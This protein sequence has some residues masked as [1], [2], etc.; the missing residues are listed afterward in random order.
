MKS[1]KDFVA[2]I[3]TSPDD[4]DLRLVYADWLEERGDPRGELVRA[5]EEMRMLAPYSDEYWSLKPIRDRLRSSCKKKWLETMRYGT[6]YE[7]TLGDIPE[8]WKER[9]RLLRAWVDRWHRVSLG[10]IG[11]QRDRIAEIQK[12]IGY[13]LPPSIQEWIAFIRD[14]I[15]AKG[16]GNVFRDALSFGDVPDHAAFSLMV[17][18]EDDYHWAVRKKHLREKDPPVDGYLLDYD[19]DDCRFIHDRV[20]ASR[21]TAWAFSH[22]LTYLGISSTGGCG[23]PVAG[24]DV[25]TLREKLRASFPVF[26]RLEDTE[27]FEAPNLIAVMST[28]RW[29]HR[30]DKHLSVHAWKPVP[31]PACLR[32]YSSAGWS[33]GFLAK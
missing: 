6:D 23:G 16:F 18:G 17:Q 13:A 28:D 11:G 27:I 21:V 29:T 8:G 32:K 14:L 22:I 25:A 33:S 2:A 19:R 30:S 5:E 24:A 4:R 3:A 9:W 10:D 20:L 15:D 26:G 12:K 7:P 1:E 31:L